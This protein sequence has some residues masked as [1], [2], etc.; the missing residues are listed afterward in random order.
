MWVRTRTGQGPPDSLAPTRWASE[1]ASNHL[2]L[3]SEVGEE[4]ELVACRAGRVLGVWQAC[5]RP[6]QTAV[7][8]EGNV[9]PRP[10]AMRTSPDASKAMS[11]RR[12]VASREELEERHRPLPRWGTVSKSSAGGDRQ[13]RG[14]NSAL[15][16]RGRSGRCSALLCA[17]KSLWSL[18][19]KGRLPGSV[20]KLVAMLSLH[21]RCDAAPSLSRRW[22]WLN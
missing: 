9:E 5:L 4:K 21:Q 8:A 20:R 19:I 1:G 11:R 16:P 2:E 15:V 6:Q 17:P 3:A 12:S 22:E 10:G 13:G 7:G 14:V 18:S